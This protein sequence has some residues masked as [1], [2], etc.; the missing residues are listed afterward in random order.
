MP[1]LG[2]VDAGG[3]DVIAEAASSGDQLLRVEAPIQPQEELIPS[4][5]SSPQPSSPDAIEAT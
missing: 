2:Q 3:S 1:E 5:S 4:R